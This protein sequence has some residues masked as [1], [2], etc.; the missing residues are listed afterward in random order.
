MFM[1]RVDFIALFL[2]SEEKLSVS[3]IG[4]EMIAG[5][6]SYMAFYVEAVFF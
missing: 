2:I 6:F 5:N 4:Q 3:P 1:V